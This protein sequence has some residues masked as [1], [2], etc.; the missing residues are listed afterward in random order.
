MRTEPDSDEFDVAR[1][2]GPVELFRVF[3]HRNYRLFFSGQ[4]VSLMGTWMQS[5]SQGWLVHTSTH[6]PLLLGFAAFCGQVPV[7]FVSPFGGRISDR[8]DRRRMLILTQ[9]PSMLQAAILAGLTPTHEVRVWNVLA[10]ALSM[11]DINAFDVPTSHAFTIEMVGWADLRNAI[12]LNSVMFNLARIVGPSAAGVLV[13]AA[14]EGICFAM[15]AFS[16]G[17][18]LAELLF[19]KSPPWKRPVAEHPLRELKAGIV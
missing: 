5:V 1:T 8:V 12:A 11:G 10:L 15:N 16:Y 6:S 2:P 18:V 7:F 14:G 19:M 17:A 9:S 4:L 13:A 3:R